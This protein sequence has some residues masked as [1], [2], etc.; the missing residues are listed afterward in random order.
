MPR[1]SKH[2]EVP[3][4]PPRIRRTCSQRRP[5]AGSLAGAHVDAKL[6]PLRAHDSNGGPLLWA[7]RKDV[8]RRRSAHRPRRRRGSSLDRLARAS[9][10]RGWIRARRADPRQLATGSRDACRGER[11]DR[12]AASRPSSHARHAGSSLGDRRRA[13]R[14]HKVHGAATPGCSCAEPARARVGPSV[15]SSRSRTWSARW[16]HAASREARG[17]RATRTSCARPGRLAPG[18]LAPSRLAPGRRA[19]PPHHARRRHAGNRSAR[20]QRTGT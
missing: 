7:V 20:R 2:A 14:A 13:R 10:A 17:S 11:G 5:E 3:S 1:P 18:R 8:R 15:H 6:P 9:K 4:R 16:K 12:S 19:P